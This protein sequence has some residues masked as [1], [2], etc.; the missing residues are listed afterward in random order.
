ML[1]IVFWRFWGHSIQ[2]CEVLNTL[3]GSRAHQGCCRTTCSSFTRTCASASAYAFCFKQLCQ[4]LMI[5]YNIKI[6]ISVKLL[7]KDL[8]CSECLCAMAV[9]MF[10][11]ELFQFPI[12]RSTLTSTCFWRA[13]VLALNVQAQ[14]HLHLHLHVVHEVL[15]YVQFH[16]VHHV[17]GP[18]PVLHVQLQQL[19][20]GVFLLNH[21][22]WFFCHLFCSL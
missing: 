1:K 17:E 8:F 10:S 5:I 20:A 21:Y 2:T 15:V 4:L 3:Q 18:V 9:F 11:R 13:C 7:V 16:V 22:F 6:N 14:M 19:V 12:S